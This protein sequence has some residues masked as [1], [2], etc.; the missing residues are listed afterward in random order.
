MFV[1]SLFIKCQSG[2]VAN[3]YFQISGLHMDRKFNITFE[4]WVSIRSKIFPYIYSNS[5]YNIFPII[6]YYVFYAVKLTSINNLRA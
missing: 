6:L 4:T 5:I 3:E 1:K 2:R